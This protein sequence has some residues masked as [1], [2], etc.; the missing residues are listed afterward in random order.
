MEEVSKKYKGGRGREER[1]SDFFLGCPYLGE[2]CA[3]I[4]SEIFGCHG[5]NSEKPISVPITRVFNF[6]G[7][8]GKLFRGERSRKSPGI[9]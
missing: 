8:L 9:E 7:F 6:R 1:G 4:F 3:S 5:T 2:D